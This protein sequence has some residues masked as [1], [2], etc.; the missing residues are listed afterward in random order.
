MSFASAARRGMSDKD[1]QEMLLKSLPSDGMLLRYISDQTPKICAIA[2]AQNWRAITCVRNI[3]KEL[4]ENVLRWAPQCVSLLPPSMHILALEINRECFNFIDKPSMECCRYAIETYPELITTRPNPPLELCLIAVRRRFEIALMYHRNRY[5]H[6]DPLY[7]LR[8]DYLLFIQVS[9]EVL[10]ELQERALYITKGYAILSY[11]SE[12][13]ARL[14]ETAVRINPALYPQLPH[15]HALGC[16][17]LTYLLDFPE[18]IKMARASKVLKKMPE[19]LED[20]V[21]LEPIKKN[22]L[23]VFIIKANGSEH[24][25]GTADTILDLVKR[26]FRGSTEFDIFVPS[27]NTLIPTSQLRL[28]KVTF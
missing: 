23:C 18:R 26:K 24:F 12:A 22:T 1:K 4:L 3:S 16:A 2:I 20:P 8:R 11:P 28:H 13:Q 5:Y 27:Q 6:G 7:C 21:S 14:F 9:P 17:E 25:V 19:A 15:L 10:A